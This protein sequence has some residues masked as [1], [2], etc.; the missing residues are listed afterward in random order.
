MSVNGK[1]NSNKKAK[2]NRDL[3]SK[4]KKITYLFETMS[5][6]F[7]YCKLTTKK[8]ISK[9]CSFRVIK[10]HNYN[11]GYMAVLKPHFVIRLHD[12]KNQSIN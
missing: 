1:N 10:I 12:C 9:S 7:K 5:Y 2:L 8:I 6:P 11:K 3:N 4:Y